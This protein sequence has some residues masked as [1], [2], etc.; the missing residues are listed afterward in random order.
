MMMWIARAYR[1]TGINLK[2]AGTEYEVA[3]YM[4]GYGVV[5]G[6]KGKARIWLKDLSGEG[7]KRVGEGYYTLELGVNEEAR[8][9][10]RIEAREPG[11]MLTVLILLLA[12]VG[13]AVIVIILLK[14]KKR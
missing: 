7:L 6:H 1:M 4:G 14:R 2:I 5:A 13:G 12:L 10:T 9:T 8:L 3:G 11:S